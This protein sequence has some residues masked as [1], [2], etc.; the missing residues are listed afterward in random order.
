[1]CVCLFVSDLSVCKLVGLNENI[2]MKFKR[3]KSKKNLIPAFVVNET[4]NRNIEILP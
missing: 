4:E 3:I 1:M 2:C